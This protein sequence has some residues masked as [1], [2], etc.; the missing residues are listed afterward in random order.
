MLGV[1][2]GLNHLARARVDFDLS[3][4]ILRS[5]L[6]LGGAR[7]GKS[8]YAQGLAEAAAPE[9]LFLAT[10]EPFDKE[11]AARIGRHKQER[12]AGWSLREEPLAIAAALIE[13]ARPGRS[14]LVD[15]LTLW[16]NNL[17][18]AHEDPAPALADLSAAIGALTG[19]AIFVSNEVGS[20][21]VPDSKLGRD[22]RDWQGRIN[23]DV[24]A[25]CGAVVL[26]TAGL[27][28]LLKPSPPLAL[29]LQ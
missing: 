11:M 19:P 28:S 17:L 15:C 20:G 26:V 10:A 7:S 13:E 5:V 3:V 25:A 27:P 16:L 9:R 1:V 4:P 14:I 23:R 22:F 8:A 6:V 29:R 21:L 24:A 12:G 18:Y 2:Y